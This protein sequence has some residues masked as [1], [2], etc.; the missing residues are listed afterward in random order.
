MLNIYADGSALINLNEADNVAVARRE[1]ERGTELPELRVKTAEI[2]PA[3]YK[4]ATKDIA[5]GAPILKYAT[6]IG[7]AAKDIKAGEMLHNHNIAFQEFERDYA[8]AQGYTP[9]NLLPETER[10]T[11]QGYKRADGRVGTRNFIAIVSTVNCSAT[12][13][14]AIADHFTKERL[15]AYPN[16]DGVAAFAH[17]MGCGMEMTGEPMDLLH[18]TLAGYINHPNVAGALVVGLGCE[19]CQ[20]GGLFTA[21]S[22]ETGPGLRTLVMQENGGTRMTIERGIAIVEEML[23]DANR[24][25]R[26]TASAEHIMVGLQCGGSDAFSSITANPALGRA[27][28]ILAQH[29]G[30][31]VLS[32]TPE[33]YGV[34]HTLTRR[35]ASVAIGE[36]LIDRIR[37]WKDIYAIGRDVQINGVVSP[38][39]Q[40]GG[41]ANIL[42][43]SLGS[44]MK[45]G[46]G[47][48]MAVYEYAEK[49]ETP[50][51][52]FM[53]TPGFDPVSA[54]GQ[55][56]GGANLVAFTTGRGSCF[57]AKP[58]PSIKLATNTPMF[59]RMEEDMDINCGKVLDGDATMD[60]MGREIFDDFLEIASGRQSKSEVLD[61]GR[62]E[63]IPWQI[64]IVG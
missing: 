55:I 64:G 3:G 21:Q 2:V 24:A 14:H 30:T 58:T 37:W 63:F 45:G 7:F 49:V 9:I 29:G 41:L 62:H 42:E 47:P 5:K 36:K 60:E 61:L 22:M 6:V 32:E 10:A 16:V 54:T 23:A 31:G 44:A 39:N 8:H 52:V 53:D 43:K 25:T 26:E 50:G 40:M 38:G 4:V 46:T 12:V 1:M 13:V 48:L 20:V 51:F 34:E 57:G 11:F 18:R 35:A 33:I 56:A 17:A 27:V 19:R 15:A 59:R 28:D